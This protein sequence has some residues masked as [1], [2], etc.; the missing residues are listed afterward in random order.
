[1]ATKVT[2]VDREILLPD[3]ELLVSKTDPK[4]NITYCNR[5]F[6]RVAGYSEKD[7]L[8]TQ[9]NVTRHPDMP[10]GIFRHLW[11]TLEEGREYFGYLK[12]MSSD[13]AFYWVFTHIVPSYDISGKLQGYHSVRRRARS[14]SVTIVEPIYKEMLAL[15]QQG[16]HNDAP[17]RSLAHMH[18]RL[19]EFGTEYEQFILDI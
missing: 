16:D 3:S 19:N 14:N 10:R 1:M 13:G 17:V 8:K 5:A 2:P 9:H 12:N 7:L 6:M 11:Q 15:E 18:K 4:G